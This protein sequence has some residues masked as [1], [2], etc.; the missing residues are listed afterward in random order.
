M[1]RF[2]VLFLLVATGLLL[3]VFKFDSGD[4]RFLEGRFGGGGR[5]A[6]LDDPTEWIRTSPDAG[7]LQNGQ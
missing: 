7:V 1:R 4:T 2:F 3:I 6:D 5:P